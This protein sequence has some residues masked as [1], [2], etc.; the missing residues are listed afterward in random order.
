MKDVFELIERVFGT[1]TLQ[2]VAAIV[3]IYFAAIGI[4]RI[5]ET[6]RSLSR[7][8]AMLD[9]EKSGLEVLKLRYEIAV[10]RKTHDLPEI[11]AEGLF[12]PQLSRVLEPAPS[13]VAV[14]LAERLVNQGPA[15]QVILY[16][17]LAI[18]QLGGW[19]AVGVVVSGLRFRFAGHQLQAYEL[20]TVL[21]AAIIAAGFL[22]V[23]FW[24]LGPRLR[25]HSALAVRMISGTTIIAALI[26][27]V[28]A[29]SIQ[30]V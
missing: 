23:A 8:K 24:Q 17:A 18:L 30:A 29:L 22:F 9:H 10:L 13:A 3:A 20:Y 25:Q 4:M 7:T 16:I 21:A 28:Y 12:P 15:G 5:V 26:A 11:T 1:G 27:V 14:R 19:L 2:L 6:T